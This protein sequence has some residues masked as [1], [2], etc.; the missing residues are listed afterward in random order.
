M[1]VIPCLADMELILTF[2]FSLIFPL[3]LHQW[4]HGQE[5]LR[6]RLWRC[7]V[8]HCAVLNYN[9][10]YG[11]VLHCALLNC[12]L[13]Y[14]TVLHCALLNCNLLYGTVLHWTVLYCTILTCVSVHY[15][16]YLTPPS[17]P[18]CVSLSVLLASLLDSSSWTFPGI[19]GY[20]LFFGV[21]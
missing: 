14:G 7:T 19:S 8:L 5:T 10:L 16:H 21:F 9:L 13:L 15:L 17:L 20:L 3:H 6:T 18:R 2:P 4:G 1:K 11:T 12:N